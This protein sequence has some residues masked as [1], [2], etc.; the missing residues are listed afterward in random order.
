M[1][2]DAEQGGHPDKPSASEAQIAKVREAMRPVFDGN[3]MTF[4][5]GA[6]KDSVE[7]TLHS[8]LEAK[9]PDIMS[10]SYPLF[11]RS[12]PFDEQERT[13]RML[14]DWPHHD[15]KHIALIQI[16][17][18]PREELQ[19]KKVSMAEY[20]NSFFA[21][22]PVEDTGY[23]NIYAIPEQY[24]QGY[25]DSETESLVQNPHFD[26]QVRP[27]PDIERPT[28]EQVMSRREPQPPPIPSSSPVDK[29]DMVWDVAKTK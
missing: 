20:I 11:D 18:P 24:V 14:L 10:T 12:K 28:V 1:A 6:Y 22:L 21:R 13:F 2:E 26:P 8:G 25:W 27:V 29:D 16:P 7:K 17:V 5:H 3:F 4:G 23:N 15:F 19:R 9:L